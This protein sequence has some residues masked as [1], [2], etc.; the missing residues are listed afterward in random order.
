MIQHAP[1][2]ESHAAAAAERQMRN[3]ALG[4]EVHERLERREEPC[5]G[6]PLL[7][8]PYVAISR[9][10]GAGG[11]AV[12]EQLH[13]LLGWDICGRELLDYIADRCKVPRTVLDT[14]D[15]STPNW[16]SELFGKWFDPQLVTPSEYVRQLRLVVLAA[17]RATSCVFIGRGAGFILPSKYGISVR[18]LAPL[19]M[20]I[21]RI[22]ELH[23]KGRKEAEAFVRDTDRKRRDFI[24]QQFGRDID[25]LHLYDL[26]LNRRSLDVEVAAEL[27]AQEVRRRF[28]IPVTP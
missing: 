16:V 23:G 5:W 12:A 22:M 7:I 9:E 21:A 24:A 10:A 11:G 17:A 15:E 14:I 28:A 27:I 13:R 19:E 6:S 4:L 20:R 2:L 1:N 25:D 8:C 3:W 26:A 18:L